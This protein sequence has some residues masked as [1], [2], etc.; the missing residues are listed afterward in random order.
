MPHHNK[1]VEVE[2][3]PLVVTRDV[4]TNK[5]TSVTIPS[6]LQVGSNA[7]KSSITVS[8]SVT[9]KT[10]FSGSL[11]KLADGTTDF[12]QAGSNVTITKNSDGS[13]TIASTASGGGGAVESVTAGTGLTDSGTAED[14]ELELNLNDLTTS[15][16]DG[17][18]DYFAVV[19]TGGA[20]KK[21]TKGNIN[22]S[23]FNN[24]SGF[25]TNAG[26]IEGV[27][28]GTGLSGG[29]TSGTVSL[30]LDVSELTAL[31][32]TASSSDYVVIEDVTD[33][34]TKKV[35][36]RNLPGDIEG[37]TAGN[38]LTGGGTSGA[39]TLNVGAGTGI[40]VA[41][42]AISVDVSDFMTNGV[43]NRVVT[44]TGTD[45]M[46]AEANMTFDGT[47]LSVNVDSDAYLDVAYT[48]IG[49]NVHS[50]CAYF[51]HIDQIDSGDY[52]LVQQSDGDTFLNCT[53]GKGIF[54]RSGNSSDNIISLSTS[55]INIGSTAVTRDVNVGTGAAAQ[56]VTIGSATSTSPTTIQA[57]TSGITLDS[58]G[59]VDIDFNGSLAGEVNFK[60]NGTSWGKIGEV[61]TSVSPLITENQITLTGDPSGAVVTTIGSTNSNSTTTINA[62]VTMPNQP[63]CHI[64]G[65]NATPTLSQTAT[66]L[67]FDGSEVDYDPENAFDT[68]TNYRF[69]APVAG[70]YF[71]H[72]SYAIEI[73]TA[74]SLTAR[75]VSAHLYKNGSTQQDFFGG[76]EQLNIPSNASSRFKTI[77]G[78]GIYNLS[79]N[80]Y[81]EIYADSSK[82]TTGAQARSQQTALTIY[83]IG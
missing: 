23:G 13:I 58:E 9:A 25:T 69:T 5:V 50:D 34:S 27:T 71:I 40:D 49:H 59:D 45:A 70:R 16:S 29:G 7:F 57:G 4:K 8:D 36:V 10:G 41:A 11:T 54:V 83:L 30:A 73:T 66:K 20:Q 76:V 77:Q 37:V 1:K 78:A 39:V 38:G 43:N 44:A 35:L 63:M 12:L 28:A 42:D 80:D 55:A 19:D 32:T 62:H 6:N 15:T 65:L 72:L 60:Y 26:D 81:I 51:S 2:K 31:G 61:I 22:I 82:T 48:R 75:W 3:S 24:D 47:N 53:S 33:N 14:P 67:E 68:L 79:A 46:N 17:D 56:T 52:A 18:G 64:V 74:S 21:L